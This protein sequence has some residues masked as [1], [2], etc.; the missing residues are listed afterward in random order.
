ML[1]TQTYLN[2]ELLIDCFTRSVSFQFGLST[3]YWCNGLVHI[4]VPCLIV[5]A[6]KF[7]DCLML[8]FTSYCLPDG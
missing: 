3:I 1:W 5:T 4:L 8:S 6:K 2:F 7:A